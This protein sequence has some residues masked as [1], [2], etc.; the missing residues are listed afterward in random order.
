MAKKKFKDRLD[1][2][3]YNKLSKDLAGGRKLGTAEAE[4]LQSRAKK[5]LLGVS[6]VVLVALIFVAVG[7]ALGNGGVEEPVSRGEGA[8]GGS[9]SEA[10]AS[11]SATSVSPKPLPIVSTEVDLSSATYVDGSPFTGYRYKD[12]DTRLSDFIQQRISG[13]VS[14]KYGDSP[15]FYPAVGYNAEEKAHYFYDAKHNKV[16]LAREKGDS[17]EDNRY[18]Y[19]NAGDMGMQAWIDQ[20]KPVITGPNSAEN[21]GI[22]PKIIF[23]GKSTALLGDIGYINDINR[24]QIENPVT[25]TYVLGTADLEADHLAIGA[26]LVKF[27][28]E[29]TRSDF[30]Q[31][32][33]LRFVYT[34]D[35]P[36][37]AGIDADNVTSKLNVVKIRE[38]VVEP[39]GRI[40]SK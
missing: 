10:G 18:T 13:A 38:A 29:Q 32:F 28:K 36:Y 2:G 12:G 17:V 23:K 9:V 11:A 31:S 22:Q 3:G 8:G 39:N 5:W 1:F 24:M 25:I 19:L 21:V 30:K 15:V 35:L 4:G 14:V 37:G 33:E 20:Y 16:F 7:S 6:G 34:D 40:V 26:K 27:I